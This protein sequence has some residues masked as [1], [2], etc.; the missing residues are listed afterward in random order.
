MAPTC[1]PY[2]TRQPTAA[3]HPELVRKGELTPGI[4]CA[5]EYISRRKKLLALLP[6]KS[7]ALIA[8][9]PLKMM[10]DAVPYPFRQD[11]DYL[12]IT[13]CRQPGGI[14]VLGHEFGLSM[15]MPEASVHDVTWQGKIA[16]FREALDTFKAEQAFPLSKRR[17]VSC[18]CFLLWF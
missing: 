14:A 7:A 8:A 4:T 1:R 15:F 11:A 13:G 18:P 6:E 2:S 9:A 10:T 12:Y 16:G 3:S 17:E 5:D